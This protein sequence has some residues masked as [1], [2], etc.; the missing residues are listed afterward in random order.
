M[1]CTFAGAAPSI[2]VPKLCSCIK[3]SCDWDWMCSYVLLLCIRFGE[4]GGRR[5]LSQPKIWLWFS[6]SNKIEIKLFAMSFEPKRHLAAVVLFV[7]SRKT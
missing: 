2:I 7:K 5:R 4:L 6:I 1:I 3:F